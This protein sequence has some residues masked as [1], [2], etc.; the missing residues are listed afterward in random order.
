MRS[1]RCPRKLEFDCIAIFVTFYVKKRFLLCT[2]LH[3]CIKY[4]TRCRR[5]GLIKTRRGQH[6][7]SRESTKRGR[8]ETTKRYIG[9]RPFFYGLKNSI[10]CIFKYVFLLLQIGYFHYYKP[11]LLTQHVR[12]MKLEVNFGNANMS[13]IIALSLRCLYTVTE[14]LQVTLLLTISCS[15]HKISLYQNLAG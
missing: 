11:K 8:R 13:V 6:K 2:D 5:H 3:Q 12:F 4:A 10:F 9:M 7:L 15:Y 1:Q 14:V